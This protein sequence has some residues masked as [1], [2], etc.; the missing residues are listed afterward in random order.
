MIVRHSETWFVWVLVHTACKGAS[1]GN[2]GIPQVLPS[3]C[4]ETSS[5]IGLI[6]QGGLASK[7]QHWNYKC[8]P[9]LLAFLC[10]FQG[11]KSGPHLVLQAFDQLSHPTISRCFFFLSL[12]QSP[13][14]LSRSHPCEPAHPLLFISPFQQ[15]HLHTLAYTF[16]QTSP[17][18]CAQ[19]T[20][21]PPY[22]STA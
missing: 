3:L 4:F 14:L 5:L 2:L 18:W 20:H 17:C 21:C 8:I 11:S 19:S 9:P 10:G 16:P 13:Q 1:K 22:S 15:F 12:L 6:R 7:P